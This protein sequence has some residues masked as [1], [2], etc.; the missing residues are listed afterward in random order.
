M[1]RGCV[2]A[3]CD[4]GP[5]EVGVDTVGVGGG[6]SHTLVSSLTTLPAMTGSTASERMAFSLSSTPV[7]TLPW[8]LDSLTRNE[9]PPALRIPPAALMPSALLQLIVEPATETLPPS[10][11]I[12]PPASPSVATAVFPEIV[13]FVTVTSPPSLRM[14]PPALPAVDQSA[15]SL[16]P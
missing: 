12:P 3:A 8:T 15:H 14:P 9:S 2:A 4:A 7:A 5:A 1:K 13:E 11:A 6:V 16:A 10:E